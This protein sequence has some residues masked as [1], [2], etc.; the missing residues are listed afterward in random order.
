VP[1]DVIPAIDLAGGR[2]AAYAPEGPRPVDAFGGDPVSAAEAFVTAGARWLHVVDMDMA[3]TGDPL[4]I[5]TVM[6]IRRAALFHGV[7]IQAS[8]GLVDDD[9][10][11]YL[12]DVGVDRAVIGS[13][14]LADPARVTRLAAD[15]GSRLAVGLEID[16]DHIRS[17]GEVSIELPLRDTL[18]WLADTGVARFMVTAV[19]RVATLTGPDLPNLRSVVAIGRP[20][21]AAGGIASLDDLRAVRDEGAEAAIVGRAALEGGLDLQAAFSLREG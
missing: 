18:T 20:V 3:F 12:L 15:L 19:R 8:G 17:R 2:L 7:R 9:D 5:G 1:F 11:A 4:N 14:A 21:V 13:A 10:L 6:A 16:G